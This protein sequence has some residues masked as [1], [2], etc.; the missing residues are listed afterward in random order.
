MKRILLLAVMVLAGC[1]KAK[2]W[3]EEK[4]MSLSTEQY[5]DAG[6]VIVYDLTG[7]GAVEL[8]PPRK[9]SQMQRIEIAAGCYRFDPKEYKSI[10][11]MW[12][13]TDSKLAVA[14]R[15]VE[16]NCPLKEKP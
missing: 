7:V 9:G 6:M 4:P 8:Y 10:Q 11:A 15:W 5:P 13:S 14:E 3:T 2:H 16:Q 1:G 12:S